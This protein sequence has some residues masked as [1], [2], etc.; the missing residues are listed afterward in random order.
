M[1]NQVF[2]VI[3]IL[4]IVM[5]LVDLV[6]NF[7]GIL[8]ENFNVFSNETYKEAVENAVNETSNLSIRE[9]SVNNNEATDLTTTHKNNS[10]IAHFS[11][12]VYGVIPLG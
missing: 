2:L 3:A 12:T 9:N 5:I 4:F 7:T 1:N 8:Q 10:V 6:F 11:G